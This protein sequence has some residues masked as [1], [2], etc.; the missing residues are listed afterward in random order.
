SF[1]QEELTAFTA[2]AAGGVMAGK[3][4]GEANVLAKDPFLYEHKEL[5]VPAGTVTINLKNE[6]AIVHTL[7]FEGVDGFEKLIASGTRRQAEG[8]GPEAN[9][10]ADLKPGTYVFYCDER[11]H[12]GA[13]MEGKLT[14]S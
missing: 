4:G 12:R 11:G 14:V 6:G 3:G 13:G 2:A 8:K 5:T 9:G 7:A 1:G 10:T